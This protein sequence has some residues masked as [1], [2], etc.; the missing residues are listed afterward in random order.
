[1][2]HTGRSSSGRLS[3]W[4]VSLVFSAFPRETGHSCC[5]G[6]PSTAHS[7]LYKRR[8]FQARP[9]A[10]QSG[11]NDLTDGRAFV[12]SRPAVAWG[13]GLWYRSRLATRRLRELG[14]RD[15]ETATEG[16]RVGHQEGSPRGTQRPREPEKRLAQTAGEHL[17]LQRSHC[18]ESAGKQSGQDQKRGTQREHD[19]NAVFSHS[20][21]EEL[22]SRLG[23]RTVCLPDSQSTS[24]VP[25][26]WGKFQNYSTC[27]F[28]TPSKGSRAEGRV[29]W[30]Q[31]GGWRL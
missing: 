9:R 6:T 10:R 20:C 5:R 7:L 1:M 18:T 25:T 15:K 24:T 31:K 4:P 3:S 28:Q 26:A 27:C 19:Q 11:Q 12:P 16:G 21:Q 8:H 17:G 2:A 13:L 29:G 30:L 22:S 23:G 14:T